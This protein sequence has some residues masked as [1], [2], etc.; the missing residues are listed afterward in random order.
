MNPVLFEIP[1]DL[2]SLFYLTAI[3]CLFL[4]LWA[5]GRLDYI[6]AS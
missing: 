1:V 5:V 2:R 4:S 6:N 3:L